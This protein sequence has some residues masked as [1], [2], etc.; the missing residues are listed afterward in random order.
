M[1]QIGRM[2]HAAPNS[3]S[4]QQPRRSFVA[5]QRHFGLNPAC[6]GKPGEPF[7]PHHTVARYDD[8]D[9]I[10][11]AGLSDRLRRHA[12]RFGDIPVGAG[13]AKRNG[14]N[15]VTNR[16]L[17]R[18]APDAQRQIKLLSRPVIIF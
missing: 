11:P 17:K 10:C 8:R 12:E 4:D 18:A 6:A 3:R 2:M 1:G 5:Q 9:R 7:G 15:G 14:V 16:L 13:I